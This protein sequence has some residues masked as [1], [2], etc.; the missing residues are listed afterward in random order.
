VGMAAALL[1]DPEFLILD[2]P[3][4]GLDPNQLIAIRKLIKTIGKTKTVFLSTHIMQEVE[5][6]CDRVLILHQGKIVLDRPL[7]ELASKQQQIIKVSFDY[8][9]EVEALKRIPSVE[10]VVNTHDFNY[11]VYCTTSEDLRPAIFDFAHDNA[12]K[13]L[14][15]QHKVEDLEKQFRSLTKD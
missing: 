9:V 8:R 12:L 10:K 5:A 15:L 11:E 13:I 4:T 2:E 1:H 3:T 14:N 7:A 6:L